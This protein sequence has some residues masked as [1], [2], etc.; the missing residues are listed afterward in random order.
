LPP[1]PSQPRAETIARPPG[2]DNWGPSPSFGVLTDLFELIEKKRVGKKPGY[3]AEQLSQFFS[4]R[5]YPIGTPTSG[6][7]GERNDADH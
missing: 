2:Y 3:R 1:N 6:L 4:V 5:D 7:P